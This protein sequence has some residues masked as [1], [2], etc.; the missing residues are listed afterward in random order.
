VQP[1]LLGLQEAVCTI[2]GRTL[3]LIGYADRGFSLTRDNLYWLRKNLTGLVTRWDLAR[4]YTFRHPLILG[5][6][7]EEQFVEDADTRAF[8][9]K[10]RFYNDLDKSIRLTLNPIARSIVLDWELFGSDEVGVVALNDLLKLET[11]VAAD[12]TRRKAHGHGIGPTVYDRE[13]VL[14]RRWG[15]REIHLNAVDFGRT[16]WVKLGFVPQDPGFVAEKYDEWA[17]AQGVTTPLPADPKHY[18][19]DFL[20][21][22]DWLPLYK[23]VQ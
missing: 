20:K 1:L 22:F 2:A 13:L 5:R 23:V 16:K 21:S 3:S 4:T 14:Y 17:R 7:L 9:W 15:V 6:A 8:R 10:L 12:G 19:P 18:P 11:F